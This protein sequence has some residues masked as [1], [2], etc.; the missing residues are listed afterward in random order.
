MVSKEFFLVINSELSKILIFALRNEDGSVIYRKEDLK[1]VC[2]NFCKKLYQTKEETLEQIEM[3][4][5]VLES[6][7]KFFY[8]ELKC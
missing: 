1:I 6:L 3:R 5:E 7:S 2:Y 4:V 8:S